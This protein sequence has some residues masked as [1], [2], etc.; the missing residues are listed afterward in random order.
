MDRFLKSLRLAI[1]CAGAAA[2]LALPSAVQGAFGC[3]CPECRQ[4]GSQC[5]QHDQCPNNICNWNGPV[6]S[7]PPLGG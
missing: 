3:D 7:C 5:Y 2:M 1:V 4:V 6:C